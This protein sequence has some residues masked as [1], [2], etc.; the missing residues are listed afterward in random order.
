MLPYLCTLHSGLFG[1]GKDTRSDQ[2]DTAARTYVIDIM[3]ES[4]P[5]LVK[6]CY[7]DFGRWSDMWRIWRPVGADR[8]FREAPVTLGV[9]SWAT[10]SIDLWHT[11][12]HLAHLHAPLSDMCVSH[13]TLHSSAL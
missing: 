1:A 6:E 8:P 2:Q 13:H 10:V 11:T 12:F 7:W 5:T 3:E 4:G 9:R